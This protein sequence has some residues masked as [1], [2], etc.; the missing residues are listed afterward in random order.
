MTEG[1]EECF[2]GGT[3]FFY[4]DSGDNSQ[5]ATAIT[6]WKPLIFMYYFSIFK[7]ALMDLKVL[8]HV[9]LLY[10]KCN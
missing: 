9:F 3:F 8:I 10:C 7:N 6:L 4:I 1:Q 2:E 5:C